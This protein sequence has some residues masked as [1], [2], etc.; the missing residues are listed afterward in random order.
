MN[1]IEAIEEFKT[2]KYE[3]MVHPI[4]GK[5]RHNGKVPMNNGAVTNIYDNRPLGMYDA[6]LQDWEMGPRKKEK[7]TGWINVYPNSNCGM[8]IY[9]TREAAQ[10]AKLNVCIDT[11]E[12]TWYEDI[13]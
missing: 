11:I 9:S 13:C 12:I 3:Y 7:R 8:I 6:Y 10:D 1:I 5:A 4:F 2:G